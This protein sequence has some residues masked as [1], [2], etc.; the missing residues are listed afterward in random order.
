MRNH[1]SKSNKTLSEKVRSSLGL[2]LNVKMTGMLLSSFLAINLFVSILFFGVVIWKVEDSAQRYLNIYD[3]TQFNSETPMIEGLGY[4][5]QQI[6]EINRGIQFPEPLQRIMA[7]EAED[8][9]RWMITPKL[10]PWVRLGD[11]M[12]GTFYYT[13]FTQDGSIYQISYSMGTDIRIYLS[14]LL[15][16]LAFELVYLLSSLGKNTRVLRKVLRPLTNLAETAQIL[17]KDMGGY[18][19][20]SDLKNLA[21]ALGDIDVDQLD[22][23][24]AVDSTQHELKDLAT[25]IN[26]M[27]NRINKS[28]QTQVR[29][30]S[31]ASHELRTPISVIQGYINLLDRWGKQ[32]EKVMQESIDAIKGETD[33]MKN[34]VEQLLFLARGDNETIQLQLQNFDICVTVEEIIREARLIDPN[35]IFQ[36]KLP[37]SAEFTGDKQ[38]LKQAIRILVDNSIKY[39]PVGETIKLSVFTEKNQVSIRVQDNGIGIEPEDLSHIF[40]RFYRSDES[41]AR[42]TGGA[43]L[44]LAIA[45]WIVERHNGHFQVMSRVDIG[46]RTTIVLPLRE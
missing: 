26:D 21:G 8:T 46:T 19:Q 5:I 45:K 36:L 35:H 30:V 33:N 44:G 32:D 6:E 27:L 25:A 1:S 37:A 29:F 12:A 22:R 14:L 40:D 3:I 4:Q 2:K 34:L 18:A 39:T 13:A 23:R 15:V 24:I 28:Y 31:D 11:R 17:Q 7:L 42:K 9:H 20:G 10:F 41:R 16:V 38:L 43:G